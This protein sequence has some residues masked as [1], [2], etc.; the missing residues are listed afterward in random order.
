VTLDDLGLGP[1]DVIDV[2][3]DA[4]GA[5]SAELD[6]RVRR[7]VVVN[8]DPRP[9][10]RLEIR[11]LEA[12]AGQVSVFAASAL[13]GRLRAMVTQSRPLRASDVAL[14]GQAATADAVEHV[15]DRAR[16]DGVATELED[17]RDRLDTAL[18]SG[19]ALLA[20][21]VANRAALLSGI[22]DRIAVVVER[23]VE[24]AGFGGAT[25][26]WGAAYDWRGER[27]HAL[28]SRMAALLQ[29]WAQ[30]LVDCNAS[31][32]AEEDLPPT[33]P[34]EERVRH[35][36]AA[37]AQVSTTLAADLDPAA[38]RNAVIAKRNAF[39]AKRGAMQTATVAAPDPGLAD[40]LARCTSVLPIAAFDP[41][42]L[43]FVD[44]EDSIVRY[45]ED[46]QAI[47]QAARD[48]VD[49]RLTAA[50]SALAAHDDALDA[51]TRLSA[52][53]DGAAAIFGE[54][55]RLIPT[56]T[57][58]A[59]VAAELT[60]A[61]AAFTSG[62]LLDHASTVADDDFPLDTWFYGA[63]RVRPAVRLLEDATMLWD[64]H[65]LDPGQLFAL[66]LPHRDGAPW[67]ALDFPKAAAPDSE[68]LA[69]VAFAP[70][71]YDPAGPRCGLLLDDWSETIPAIEPDDA[72]PLHTT[73]VAFHFDRPSQEPPQAMLLVTPAT[74]DGQW[75]WDDVVHGV[76]DTF[77]LARLRA[78]EP[79]QLEDGPLAQFLPATVASVTT[80]GL[81]ISA[82]YA[83]V[84]ME[85]NYVRTLADG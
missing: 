16:V 1:L 55:F 54:G 34:D 9:D 12:D 46:L 78:V 74:W 28:L 20:D 62:A 58:P 2:V 85:V 80:S 31:L 5:G 53:Q 3:R 29:R 30:R 40:R 60:A 59:D 83:L 8:D 26:G 76:I 36:R 21:P 18:A 44:I 56:F 33:A 48:D 35:L 41:E 14:P 71:G 82:N 32:A 17:L 63:A 10:A 75:S 23:L 51:A 67:L 65:E 47:L 6:D 81:S 13:V 45:Q 24:A 69:Y 15:V 42:P 72:G 70:S 64:A 73:G 52:L 39:D 66:Q 49:S 7:H 27:F 19:A 61:H 25:I 4:G 37:E 57:P 11:Y 77:S 50:T 22:D 43:T 68:R 79:A 38:L 84:N